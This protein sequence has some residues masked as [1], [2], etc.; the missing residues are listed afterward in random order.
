MIATTNLLS[1]DTGKT[2]GAGPGLWFGSS[3]GQSS[4]GEGIEKVEDIRLNWVEIAEGVW[5]Q[6]Y[7][8][9]VLYK[10][11]QAGN[12]TLVGGEIKGF[13]VCSVCFYSLNLFF[14]LF[15]LKYFISNY[16]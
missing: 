15:I 4:N 8:A 14:C 12:E 6:S 7:W 10:I 5:D 13:K 2:I 9:K 3:L 1:K 11:G 16:S